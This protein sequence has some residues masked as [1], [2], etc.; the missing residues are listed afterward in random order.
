MEAVMALIEAVMAES[1]AD[2]RALKASCKARSAR[3]R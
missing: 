1:V 3:E 2:L